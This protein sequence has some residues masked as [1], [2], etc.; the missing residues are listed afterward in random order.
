MLKILSSGVPEPA[1]LFEPHDGGE[2]A[3]PIEGSLEDADAVAVT[4]E[5]YGGSPMPM[6][7][8][9]LQADL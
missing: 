2:A 3:M 9:M 6:S 1:G 7:E 5:Q 8:I 4:A